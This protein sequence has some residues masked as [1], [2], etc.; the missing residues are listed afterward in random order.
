MASKGSKLFITVSYGDAI[1]AGAATSAGRGRDK[2]AQQ[3]TA[4]NEKEG[5]F[6]RFVLMKAAR[7]A[8]GT[9][10]Q[11]TTQYVVNIGNKTGAYQM[12]EEAAYS[13]AASQRIA[14]AAITVGISVATGNYAAAAVVAVSAIADTAISVSTSQM[15]NEILAD[16]ARV[17]AQAIRRRAGL[18]SSDNGGR[19]T[20]N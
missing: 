17:N 18:D 10:L 2:A 1:E 14:S 11:Y 19:G 13:L 5:R 3:K 7:E 15:N 4:S 12:Q 20:E 8:L 16:N 9:A 6:S